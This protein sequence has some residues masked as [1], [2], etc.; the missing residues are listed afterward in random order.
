MKL[1]YI[2]VLSTIISVMAAPA[3]FTMGRS[4]DPRESAA[5]A[6][7]T[8]SDAAIRQSD[9]RLKSL[10]FDPSAPERIEAEQGASRTNSSSNIQP[11]R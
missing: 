4:E 1:I 8:D 11:D 7:G 9:E 10:L 6:V 5:P 3:G 2:F